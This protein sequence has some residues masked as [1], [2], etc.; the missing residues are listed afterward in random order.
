MTNRIAVKAK[1]IF[2]SEKFFLDN[3]A[4]KI[5]N[6][7]FEKIVPFSEL[8]EDVEI[9]D[10]TDY[11]IS[12]PFCDYHLHF[13]K[14]NLP[15]IKEITS[16]F[17]SAGILKVFEGGDCNSSG[18]IARDKL[19]ST[20]EVTTAGTALYKKGGYGKFLGIGIDS[21]HEARRIIQELASKRVDYI[22]VINSGIF[23][24]QKDEFSRGGF[25]FEELIEIV[26]MA[27]D[28]GLK[29]FCHANSDRAIREAV[30]AG[31]DTIIH[32][33]GVLDDTL[34]LMANH[35]V[36]FIPTINA[37]DCL[38]TMAENNPFSQRIKEHTDRHL[39]A[40]KKAFKKGIKV[41][42]GSDSGPPFIPYGKAF[43][44]ELAFFKKASVSNEKILASAT[45]GAL[46]PGTEAN[47]IVLEGLNVK[48]VFYRGVEIVL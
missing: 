27:H 28:R 26:A 19:K 12:P 38:G 31:V 48:K 36:A 46:V 7:T 23:I 42:A 15:H 30:E 24:P 47:F 32:G 13:S 6:N 29:V 5:L 2:T 11:T 18:F 16:H 4:V 14:K 17:L 21:P 43:S 34:T 37:L 8:R 1:R 45:F 20:I 39:Q 44:E 35:G 22:K 10:F 9:L 41:L 25:I 33:F 3:H 40:I